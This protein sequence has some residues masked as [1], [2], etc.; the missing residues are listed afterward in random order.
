MLVSLIGL[1]T[2][3]L[4]VIAI[5][6]LKMEKSMWSSDWRHMFPGYREAT[7]MKGIAD[8]LKVYSD[9][10]DQVVENLR[11][12]TKHQDDE[13]DR[14]CRKIYDVDGLE[15]QIKDLKQVLEFTCTHLNTV[16]Q[17]L[18]VRMV[19]THELRAKVRENL[20]KIKTATNTRKRK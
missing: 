1:V 7:A 2:I 10:Q 18:L 14:L 16:Q 3:V 4:V 19:A 17:E 6:A 9:G 5:G 12:H 20:K 15:A 8:R 13:I 11:K